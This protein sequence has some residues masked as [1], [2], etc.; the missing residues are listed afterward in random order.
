MF[1]SCTYRSWLEYFSFMNREFIV[2]GCILLVQTL[3]GFVPGIRALYIAVLVGFHTE[4][5]FS[6][7]HMDTFSWTW[8]S[9]RCL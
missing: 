4:K 1:L 6:C 2:G 7:T 3:G 8:S 5:H 9:T